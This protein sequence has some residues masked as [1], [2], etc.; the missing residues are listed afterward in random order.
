MLAGTICS[1]SSY[2]GVWDLPG[3][4]LDEAETPP[5]ALARELG[6]ELGIE[7]TVPTAAWRVV[8]GDGDYRLHL[9]LVRR[10]SGEVV[11]AEPMEHD[12]LAWFGAADLQALELAH[13]SYRD[14]IQ[15]ALQTP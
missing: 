8:D 4:H 2:P 11:N 6:E 9:F 7:A 3:G 1:T 13:D 12:D 5:A 15:D 10:W 14:L